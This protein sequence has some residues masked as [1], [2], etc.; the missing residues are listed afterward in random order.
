M[1]N[2]LNK[3]ELAKEKG[4]Y[5]HVPFC[6]SLCSYCDFAKMH[7]ENVFVMPYLKA[8]K[9]EIDSY[10]IK[11]IKTIYIGGGS[12]SCLDINELEYLFDI[13]KPLIN[14]DIEEF[15]FEANIEH[16]N[17][18]KLILLKSKGVNRLSFGVQSSNDELLKMMNRKHTFNDVKEIISLA[19]EVGFENI[20]VD[21]ILGF[22]ERTLLDLKREIHDFLSLNV[23]HISSYC[24]TIHENTKFYINKYESKSDDEMVD[25]LRLVHDILSDKGYINYELSNFALKEEYKSAHNLIYWK[26]KEYYGVGLGASGYLNNIWYTN[27][28]NLHKYIKGEYIQESEQINDKDD[29]FYYLMLYLRLIEGIDLKEFYHSFSIDFLTCFPQTINKWNKSGHL[30]INDDRIYLS[31]E[32]R[33]ILHT[34]L[35]DLFKEYED[36]LRAK[37]K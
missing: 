31:F 20:S 25:E 2:N 30:L 11:D 5:I 23:E 34:I 3:T 1:K 6:S 10:N 21:L 9:H 26:N 17:K 14:D 27:T 35:V 8:L 29:L 28:R 33:L 32:G 12:P 36:G 16:I 13:L 4:L 7:K 22:K 18:E 15:T 19:R 37:Q 24:L